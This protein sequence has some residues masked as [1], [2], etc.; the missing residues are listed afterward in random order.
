MANVLA[1]VVLTALLAQVA[2]CAEPSAVPGEAAVPVS[3]K[4]RNIGENVGEKATLL[5]ELVTV[6]EAMEGGVSAIHEVEDRL[7]KDLEMMM[8]VEKEMREKDALA[9]ANGGEP[10]IEGAS[11]SSIITSIL[12]RVRDDTTAMKNMMLK[13]M[14]DIRRMVNDT[15][16]TARVMQLFPAVGFQG[17]LEAMKSAVTQQMAVLQDILGSGANLPNSII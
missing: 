9:T 15:S 7:R 5:P 8:S 10:L 1:L 16:V 13:E 2:V 14:N 12:K 11:A 17:T 3:N 6:M 4:T